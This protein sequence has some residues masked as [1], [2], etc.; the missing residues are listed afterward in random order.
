[1]S[2]TMNTPIFFNDRKPSTPGWPPR[3]RV[4]VT[5]PKLGKPTAFFLLPMDC[6]VGVFGLD[7]A[8]THSGNPGKSSSVI[9]RMQ[10]FRFTLL[11]DTESRRCSI[12]AMP[13]LTQTLAGAF[14]GFLASHQGINHA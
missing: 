4:D 7:W 1:M 9:N 5:A 2:T 8:G 10:R 11:L 6:S 3:W 12:L 13:R 14:L